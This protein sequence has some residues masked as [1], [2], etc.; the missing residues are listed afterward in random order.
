MDFNATFEQIKVDAAQLV[1]KV[2]ELIH[3]GNAHRIIIKD[4]SGHTF[5]EIPVNVAAVGVM[6]AP[7]LSA[8]GALAAMVAKFTIVVERTSPPPTGTAGSGI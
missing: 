8:V 3:E 7:V 2:R 1:E 4:T 5:M 6:L